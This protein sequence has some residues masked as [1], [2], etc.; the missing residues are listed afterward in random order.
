M[1]V[2]FSKLLP[3]FI[4]PVGLVLALII[5]GLLLSRKHRRWRWSRLVLI[6]AFL[7]LWLSSTRWVAYT[8]TRSLEWQYLP[9]EPLPEAEAI[10][11]LGGGVNFQ[12]SPRPLP[13]VNQAG[14]RMIYGA[15]LYNQGYADTVLL[16]GGVVPWLG[17]DAG[18]TTEAQSM[19]ELMMM[20]NVPEEAFLLEE[21]SRNTYENALYAREIMDRVGLN[22]ILLVTSAAHMPRSVRLFEA[23]GFEVIPAP[24]DFRVTEA[25]WQFLFDAK[26]I[27]Q[28]FHWIPDAHNLYVTTVML[29]EYVGMVVYAWR[30]WI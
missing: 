20:L 25:D 28:V 12:S 7:L 2:Y 21:E 29:K 10:V 18:V 3:P 5:G 9:A 16:S 30:G 22:K 19:A 4:Y 24:T 26:P 8:I 17:P 1:F 6:V 27:E 15:W 14:D 23:Q 11:V 13:E